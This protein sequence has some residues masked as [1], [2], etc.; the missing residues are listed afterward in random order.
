M[1][2]F[3][4][5]CGQ[6]VVICIICANEKAKK[7]TQHITSYN[8][9]ARVAIAPS[10]L[11][12]DFANLG[13]AIDAV[14]DSEA[15][16]FHLD[17]MDGSFVP[18]I[19]FGQP[20]IAAVRPRMRKP[21]EVHLMVDQPE[22]H[23]QSMAALGVDA[24]TVH[25]EACENVASTLAAIRVA[26]MQAGVALCP[27]TPVD[28]VRPL[29]HLLDIICIMSVEPGAGGQIMLPSALHKIKAVRAMLDR[30][31]PKVV[32]QVDGGVNADTIASVVAAGVDRVVAGSAVFGCV[33]GVAAATTLLIKMGASAQR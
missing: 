25:F 22:R 33:G 32:L 27:D 16:W 12:A 2:L 15:A 8:M 4:R 28:V 18:S 6:G 3:P 10:I 13:A 24:V 29:L 31:A 1:A 19:S 26:G 20:V 5:G 21:C 30:C 7:Q 14:N 17:V 23:V 9:R 11:A